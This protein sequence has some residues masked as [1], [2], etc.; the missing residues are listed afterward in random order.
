MVFLMR[1]VSGPT[2][3]A[4]VTLGYSSS[5]YVYAFP[6]IRRAVGTTKEAMK[7][8]ITEVWQ[9][10]RQPLRLPAG[11]CAVMEGLDQSACI[12]IVNY[13]IKQS[14]CNVKLQAQ[15]MQ[16]IRNANLQQYRLCCTVYCM[17][18][19]W[20]ITWWIIEN[21]TFRKLR[22]LLS[23]IVWNPYTEFR[24]ISAFL[25]SWLAYLQ[26]NFCYCLCL[27]FWSFWMPLIADKTIN[28]KLRLWLQRFQLNDNETETV[29]WI[30]EG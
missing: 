7:D 5:T 20:C 24:N 28:E 15:N 26:I 6:S 13:C 30:W 8:H 2:R 18:W 29:Q 9:S 14:S 27:C 21:V 22:M 17:C 10:M 12:A 11:L 25:W 23:L 16:S 19:A 1:K 3:G 4:S